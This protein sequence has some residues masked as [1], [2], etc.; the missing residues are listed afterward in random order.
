MSNKS[1]MFADKKKKTSHEDSSSGLAPWKILVVDD[2]ESIHTVTDLVLEDFTYHDK[3]LQ[4][5]NAYSADEAKTI[6]KENSDIAMTFLD[7]VMESDTAGLDLVHFIRNELKNKNIRI[8]L[9]TGQPGVAP[10]SEVITTYDIDDYKDKTELTNIKL[11][12]TLHNALKS[13]EYITQLKDNA[14]KLEKYKNMFNSA[15]DFIFIVDSNHNIIEANTAFLDAVGKEHE[16]VINKP[17]FDIFY[18]KVHHKDIEKNIQKSMSGE[19]ITYESEMEFNALGRR[20]VDIEFFPY[21][22]K[23]N[24]LS[25]AVVNL[26]D[27]TTDVIQREEV[28]ALKTLQ[29]DNYE[30]TI[31]SLVDA[32]EQRDSF[33][34]GHTKRVA[35]YSKKI[36]QEMGI[37]KE[38]IEQLY[39]ASMLHDI[40][41]I[42]TPDSILLK[43]GQFNSVEYE[44]IK[45]HLEVGYELLK[46]VDMYKELAEI[47]RYH[48]ERY[49]GQG[50]P[51]GLKGDEIPLLGYIMAGAD[52]FDAMTTNRIYKKRKEVDVALDEMVSLKGKQFHPDVVD[53]VVKSL[54]NITIDSSNQ[55]PTNRMDRARF[56][57]FF[58]DNLTKVY[59]KDYLKIEL[60]INISL[61]KSINYI[62]IHNMSEY[63]NKESWE[64]GDKLLF[65]IA[66]YLH[67]SNPD[68]SIFRVHGDDF[69]ILCRKE[70]SVTVEKLNYQK[71][72]VDTCVNI[73]NKSL[74]LKDID[75]ITSDNFETFFK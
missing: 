20:F 47:M 65:N 13:Y 26:K 61:Y 59:N 35:E 45:N 42:S 70:C 56:A 62:E 15:T 71:F 34:A 40:G 41:K 32:I 43:P 27:I 36:A 53:A 5:L 8:V 55:L 51:Q 49:D 28:E 67:E 4:I 1:F 72:I 63:N 69:I 7:V 74:E 3:K 46:K 10:E 54:K 21:Y 25:A 19:N 16:E 37:N 38:E 31:F 52:A 73:T 39:R 64:N 50:Y 12:T 60:S 24:K 66:K 33:T 75:N 9:R 14:I 58:K 44:L 30:Q 2:D 23:G 11:K 17:I 57:Y 68:D 6:L 29:I 18:D 22:D 48:H